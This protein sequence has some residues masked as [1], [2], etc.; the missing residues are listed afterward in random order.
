MCTPPYYEHFQRQA[1]ACHQCHPDKLIEK[2]AVPL[3]QKH[4]PTGGEKVI[5][6]MEA[7][8]YDDTY[9]PQKRY[10][11]CDSTTDPTGRFLLRLLEKCDLELTDVVLTNSVLCLP[12]KINGKHRV[13]TKQSK[14]CAHMLKQLVN[15]S[16]IKT[17]CTFGGKALQSVFRQFEIKQE[18]LKAIVG[19]EI[20][21]H[22]EFTLIPFYHP[23]MQARKT[24]S[25]EQQLKDIEKL[26]NC[27][28]RHS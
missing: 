11:T 28:A 6:V 4:P 25:T 27:I 13:C 14:N 12:C 10:I 5:V 16:G 2:E 21:L 19:K 15:D 26:K 7:P 9:N 8:N 20:Q 22:E 3:F 24:R 18:K 1:K 23:S 17:I